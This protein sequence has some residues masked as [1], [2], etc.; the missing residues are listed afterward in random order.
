MFGRPPS[1]P[2]KAVEAAL[3]RGRLDEAFRLAVAAGLLG[4]R[5][6][7]GL[8]EEIGGALLQRGQ[9]RLLERRFGEA[10]GDFDN[11]ARCGLPAGQVADWQRRARDAMDSAVQ[12]KAA[13]DAAIADVRRWMSEGSLAGAEDAL[14]RL[15]K[16]DLER[17]GLEDAIG[18]RRDEAAR[19]MAA[20]QRAAAEGNLAQA[21]QQIAQARSSD[22]NIAGLAELE[23]QI[24]SSVTDRAAEDFKQ[25]RLAR[26]AQELALLGELGR[27]RRERIELEEALRLAREAAEA[28]AAD[29]YAR[30]SVLLGRLAQGGTNAKWIADARVHL[31]EL[32]THR[33]TL[34]EGPLGLVGGGD[35]SKKLNERTLVG[36]DETLPAAVAPKTPAPPVALREAR[37]LEAAGHMLPRRLLLR[38]DGVGSFLLLRGSRISIGRSGTDSTADLPLVSDLSDRQAEIVRAGEDYFIVSEGGVELAGRNIDHALLQD[39][40][41]IRLSPRIRLKFRRP[42]LKSSTAALD[43]GEGV[44]TTSDCRRVLLWEGPILMGG[45]R[46]CHVQ[47]APGAGDF[48]LI[49]RGG[50]LYV[51]PTGPGGAA[52]PVCLGEQTAIGE[53]RLS[54]AD[55]SRAK[56]C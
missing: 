8:L 6:A 13:R 17:E 44:R 33:R 31:E 7:R 41:R 39:G 11:A 35:L 45:T 34:M 46:E 15:P 49:E 4:Q 52:T 10:R 25:G 37:P 20:A 50:R 27:A 3:R 36:G 21:A 2:M 48:L 43:L 23:L 5:G 55:W 22:R 24:V 29:R 30:A 1:P 26:A 51:K 42:S 12:E 9:D 18:K 40:D 47:L 56:V 54:V 19:A 28:L 14:E 53:L 32:E 38:I 16:D